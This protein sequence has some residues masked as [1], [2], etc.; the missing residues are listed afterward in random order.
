MEGL[1][2]C[3]GV[4]REMIGCLGTRLEVFLNFNGFRENIKSWKMDWKATSVGVE[5]TKDM[6]VCML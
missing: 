5:V 2:G 3:F 1:I 6:S 4:G